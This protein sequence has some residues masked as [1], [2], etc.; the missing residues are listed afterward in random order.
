MCESIMNAEFMWVVS[1][2]LT[3][4]FLTVFETSI[5]TYQ[6]LKITKKARLHVSTITYCEYV[7]LFIIQPQQ[8]DISS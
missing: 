4:I 3:H 7:S 1:T 6:K 2:W 5:S 8:I